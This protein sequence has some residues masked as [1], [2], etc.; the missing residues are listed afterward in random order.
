[1]FRTDI[2]LAGVAGHLNKTRGSVDVRGLYGAASVREYGAPTIP[3]G[4]IAL[5]TAA[6]SSTLF[7][8]RASSL[9]YTIGGARG[10]IVLTGLDEDREE[11]ERPFPL[12][13]LF[14]L[15]RDLRRE[16]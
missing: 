13:P 11:Q 9:K 5:A 14:P 16:E 7:S 12:P 2:I 6:V 4:A 8:S 10:R 1:M 15:R 3:I